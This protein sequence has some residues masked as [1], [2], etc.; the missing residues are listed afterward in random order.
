MMAASQRSQQ[1]AFNE[2]TKAS[3]DKANNGMF[4]SIMTYDGKN[5]QVFEDLIDEINQSVG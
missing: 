1:E 3:K 4:A 5:R 2:L